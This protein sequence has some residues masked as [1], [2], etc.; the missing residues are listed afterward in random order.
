[1][2][3]RIDYKPCYAVADDMGYYGTLTHLPSR[4]ELLTLSRLYGTPLERIHVKFLGCH[5]FLTY[6]NF[7][8]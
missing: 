2:Y 3:T 6:L 5:G 8:F 7:S 1:M 4:S